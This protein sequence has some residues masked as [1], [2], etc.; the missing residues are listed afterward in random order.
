MVPAGFPAPDVTKPASVWVGAARPKRAFARR[1][2]CEGSRHL[3]H[4]PRRGSLP[5]LHRGIRGSAS[6][7][8]SNRLL[9]AAQKSRH[10]RVA[11]PRARA[12]LVDRALVRVLVR[13][14]AEEARVVA[15]AA[16][17]PL[18]VAHLDDE[19]RR[20]G[21]PLEVGLRL[22][23][24]R[25]AARLA[26][27]VR[28]EERL[29]ALEDL[30]ALLAGR[31]RRADRA[32]LAL[33]VEPER[34][35][36]DARSPSRSTSRRRRRSR[37]SSPPSPSAPPRA[38]R[39]G[40]G[41]PSRLAMTPSKPATSSRSSQRA[42][43]RRGRAS[44]ARRRTAASPPSRAARRTASR[45]GPRRPRGGRRS[46]RSRAGIS[47]ESLRTRLSAGWRRIWSA[48][49]SSAPS[50]TTTISPSTAEPGGRCSPSASSS[51]K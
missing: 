10:R 36:G 22:P 2:G 25:R 18:V 15:E 30:L 23:A 27:R 32:E 26:L 34:E 45:G 44:R 42:A 24:A 35:A 12:D 41:S 9:L 51:G 4:R 38:S 29:D 19:L 7:R 43:P 50:R 39:A 20:H 8:P 31:R 13:A 37:R 33:V 3:H 6:S 1:R 47:A 40:T 14:E 48:S 49:K 5:S 28:A 17:L 16:L 46:R 11:L 21:A